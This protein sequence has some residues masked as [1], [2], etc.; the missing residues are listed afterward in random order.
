VLDRGLAPF[1][2]REVL[3]VVE[4]FLRT[5]SL[6]GRTRHAL[7][8]ASPAAA[9]HR[10]DE[11]AASACGRRTSRPQSGTLAAR[12]HELGDRPVRA[13]RDPAEHRPAPGER[14]VM[15]AFGPGFGAEF[16]LLEFR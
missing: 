2:R 16:A 1:V 10:G 6:A 11:R 8:P 14:G 4:E 12:E 15:G 3:A 7:D 9:D 5:R 13:R